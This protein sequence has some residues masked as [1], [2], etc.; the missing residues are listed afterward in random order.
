MRPRRRRRREATSE[1]HCTTVGEVDF[2]PNSFQLSVVTVEEKL[3]FRNRTGQVKPSHCPPGSR[4]AGVA[5]SLYPRDH[6]P[7]A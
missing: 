5:W 2:I 4:C 6:K 1:N 3:S 7:L